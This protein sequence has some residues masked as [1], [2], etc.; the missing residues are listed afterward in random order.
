[1]T[2]RIK[3]YPIVEN[4]INLFGDWLQHQREM[5]ELREM[6]GSDFARIARDLCVSPAEL[7]AVIRRGPHASD[8][9]PRLLKALGIDEATL[10]RTQPVL[11]RDMVRVCT[12][13]QQKARCGFDLD[14]GTSAQ[15][16]EEYCP[17]AP[18]IDELGQNP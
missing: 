5:R 1:M 14:E 8:E 6:N 13:C 7:D 16:Y 11:Q 17:N 10:S 4:A 9:L 18:S 15:R 2:T 3:T 12:A